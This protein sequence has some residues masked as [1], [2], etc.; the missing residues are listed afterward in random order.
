VKIHRDRPVDP[1]FTVRRGRS[2]ALVLDAFVPDAGDGAALG[3]GPD[4]RWQDG[5]AQVAPDVL[6]EGWRGQADGLDPAPAVDVARRDQLLRLSCRSE[7]LV[8]DLADRLVG[9]RES[10]PR[11]LGPLVL[12]QPDVQDDGLA[13]HRP[14][15]VR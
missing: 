12:V 4:A 5:G 6:V 15:P 14:E 7:L 9:V 3:N 8:V 11:R 10:E 2:P 13:R 1:G